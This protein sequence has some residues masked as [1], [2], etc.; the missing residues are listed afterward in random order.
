MINHLHNSSSFIE[1]SPGKSYKKLMF[2][3]HVY[4]IVE[5]YSI[6]LQLS[7]VETLCYNIKRMLVKRIFYQL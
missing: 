4:L 2:K 3:N 1:I 5:L 6:T 7:N